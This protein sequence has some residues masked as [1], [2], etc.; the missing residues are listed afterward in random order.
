MLIVSELRLLQVFELI[1]VLYAACSGGAGATCSAA[2]EMQLDMPR[3][4][5]DMQRGGE[6]MQR[7]GGRLV[8]DAARIYSAC[9]TCSAGVVR[10]NKKSPLGRGLGCGRFFIPLPHGNDYEQRYELFAKRAAALRVVS[11]RP[12]R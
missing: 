9:G 7:G 11:S 10:G 2:G 8:G 4:W 6:E 1:C 5:F 3:G 12:D